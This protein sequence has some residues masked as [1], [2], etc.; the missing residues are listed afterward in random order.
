[1]LVMPLDAEGTVICRGVK[2]TK[3]GVVAEASTKDVEVKE[4]PLISIDD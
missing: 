3:N 4:N 2:V 1:M